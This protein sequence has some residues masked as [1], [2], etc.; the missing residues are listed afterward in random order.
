MIGDC[1]ITLA[2]SSTLS[3]ADVIISSLGIV[4]S[5]EDLSMLV[6]AAAKCPLVFMLQD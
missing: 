5:L 6:L 4:R 1:F 2:I 3:L